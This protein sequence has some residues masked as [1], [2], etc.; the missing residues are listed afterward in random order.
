LNVLQGATNGRARGVAALINDERPDVVTLDEVTVRR[1]FDE[2]AASTRMYGYWAQATDGYSIGILSRVPL[3]DCTTYRQAQV[4]HAAYSCLVKVGGRR[5]WIFGTHLACCGGLNQET[6]RGQTI[7]F[8]I[9]KMI[10]RRFPVVLAGDLNS[11]T[12]GERDAPP[13]MLVIPALLA[14]GFIDS[15]RELHTVAQDPGFTVTAPPYGTWDARLDYVFHSLG[16]R[17][18]S[19]SVVSSV[20][21]YRWPS[22][23]GALLVTLV[24]SRA[25]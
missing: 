10:H 24:S 17:T 9:S 19:A 11:H 23:H 14:A 2:I 12:P 7:S 1:I 8:L 3:H 20:P 21:G 6:I 13:T 18:T 5:W 25:K 16:A 15:F 22:D 4:R